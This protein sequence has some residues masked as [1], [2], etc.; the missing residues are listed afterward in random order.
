M[1][2]F[3]KTF[4]LGE[5]LPLNGGSFAYTIKEPLGVVGAI[6]AWNYPFQMATWKSAPALACGNTVIFKPSEFTPLTAVMLAEI[7]Q[8]AGLPDGCF[9]IVQVI[10]SFKY[11]T[12]DTLTLF[13]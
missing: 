13:K 6:G 9:N 3:Y 10:Y 11:D 7:Y 2:F 8:E 1:K 12:N 5:F 4:Y